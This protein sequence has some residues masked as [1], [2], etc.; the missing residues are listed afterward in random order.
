MKKS[1]YLLT[2]IL[3]STFLMAICPGTKVYAQVEQT[4]YITNTT[5][6]AYQLEKV[7]FAMRKIVL[8]GNDDSLTVADKT[9]YRTG[10][11]DGSS[12]YF[13]ADRKSYLLI[14]DKTEQVGFIIS[15]NGKDWS[16][17]FKYKKGNK[18]PPPDYSNEEAGLLKEALNKIVDPRV[19][20]IYFTYSSFAS[21][22]NTY[23][24]TDSLE[25]IF[26]SDDTI[27]VA[28]NNF[29]KKSD[30]LYMSPGHTYLYLPDN[31]TLVFRDSDL[32]EWASFYQKDVNKA[33]RLISQEYKSEKELATTNA[34]IRNSKNSKTKAVLNGYFSSITNK[35]NDPTSANNIIKYWNGHWPGSPAYKVIFAD[36]DFTIVK[37]D[38]GIPLRRSLAA[39]VLYKE[40]GKCYAQWHAYGYEYTGGGTYSKE[41]SQW[42][43]NGAGYYIIAETKQGKEYLHSGEKCE[44]DCG[45]VK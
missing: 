42:Q 29:I 19:K 38:V 11:K 36:A 18:I 39:W 9:F 40:N 7:P 21:R 16:C 24:A 41:F 30:K 6:E 5:Y 45:I 31:E 32:S 15:P 34:A 43:L 44:F 13:T 1:S 28:G 8:K 2:S 37:N 33:N 17:Y 3:V 35:K 26:V 23:F 14:I 22:A 10:L 27:S 12:I 25:V 4:F 20:Y